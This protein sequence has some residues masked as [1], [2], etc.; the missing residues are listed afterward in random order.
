[1][2]IPLGA[3]PFVPALTNA[4]GGAASQ[5]LTQML[6]QAAVS[7]AIGEVFKQPRWKFP[8]IPEKRRRDP[9]RLKDLFLALQG[10][11]VSPIRYEDS[12]VQ[13]YME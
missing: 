10:A 2:A 8:Q 5:G 3:I 11:R 4:V 1:M 7:Q 9:D 12:I 6:A 13:L